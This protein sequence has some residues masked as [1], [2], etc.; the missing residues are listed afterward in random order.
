[1]PIEALLDIMR[2]LRHPETGCPWDL[3]QTMASLIPHTLE[4]AYEVAEAIESKNDQALC[5]ELGD[6]LFQIVFYAQIAKEE[7]RFTL[8]DV[9]ETI[10]DKL[11]RRHPHVFADA[12]IDTAEQQ[13]EAWEKLKAEE[14]S[15]KARHRGEVDHLLSDV[16][17]ALPALVRAQKIQSRVSRIGFDWPD[18]QAVVEKVQEELAECQEQMQQ[19]DLKR[20]EE[21]I[22]DLLF[23]CVNL[24]RHVGVDAENALRKANQKFITRFNEVEALARCKGKPLH[25]MSLEEMDALWEQVKRAPS[26]DTI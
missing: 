11:I 14:R 20:T 5:E 10:V 3:Q 13:T 24:S 19:A 7:Q 1:M 21:E 8:T 6:L 23:S 18:Y 9:I 17:V 25:T 22:G 16:S 2:R 4:E 26:K 15:R 12:S